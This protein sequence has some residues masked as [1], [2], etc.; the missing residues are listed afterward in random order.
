MLKS[1]KKIYVSLLSLAL[2]LVW[3][4]V[5]MAA[6][7]SITADAAIVIDEATGQVLYEKNAD[8]REYPARMTKMMT[9]ILEIEST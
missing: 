4:A 9:C 7:P 5:A 1:C 2:L 6:A 3:S 8:K